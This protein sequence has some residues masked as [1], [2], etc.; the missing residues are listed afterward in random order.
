M[1]MLA[2]IESGFEE[3]V[4]IFNQLIVSLTPFFMMMSLTPSPLLPCVL[5][6]LALLLPS[7][8]MVVRVV[9]GH[10]HHHHHHHLVFKLRSAGVVVLQ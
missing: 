3:D 4:S 9:L 2:S 5:N 1:S 7:S 10:H 6:S 8:V